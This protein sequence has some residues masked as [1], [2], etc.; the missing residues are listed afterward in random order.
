LH[1]PLAVDTV[2]CSEA[3]K[4]VLQRTGVPVTIDKIVD[5]IASILVKFLIVIVFAQKKFG[6]GERTI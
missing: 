3:A 6:G 1:L 4:R 5:L 2:D